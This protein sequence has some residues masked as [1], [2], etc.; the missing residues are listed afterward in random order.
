MNIMNMPG[1]TADASLYKTNGR[2]QS[3]T[4]QC[5]SSEGQRVVGQARV[6]GGGLG[7]GGLGDIWDCAICILVC[8][9]GTGDPVICYYACRDVGMCEHA[10]SLVL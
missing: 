6:G 5:Y 4:N 10:G 1:F 2:Y 9:G 3:A 7:G 8:T